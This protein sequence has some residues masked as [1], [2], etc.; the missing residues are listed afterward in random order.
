MAFAGAKQKV[1]VEDTWGYVVNAGRSR[2]WKIDFSMS[3]KGCLVQEMNADTG[4]MKRLHCRLPINR[5][6]TFIYD[7]VIGG[8][9]T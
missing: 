8:H 3:E 5:L 2:G 6:Q 1:M 4:E 9:V 7:K